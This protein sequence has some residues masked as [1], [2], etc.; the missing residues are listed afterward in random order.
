MGSR[1]VCYLPLDT[2]LSDSNLTNDLLMTNHY[3]PISIPLLLT[4]Q[5]CQ[6]K[7]CL[8]DSIMHKQTRKLSI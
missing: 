3:A 1:S 5:R 7:N 8:Q 6:C 2:N 4:H